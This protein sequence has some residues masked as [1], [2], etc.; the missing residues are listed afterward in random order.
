[1]MRRICEAAFLFVGTLGWWGFVYPE[2]CPVEEVYEEEAC[3]QGAYGEEVC[4]Q[5]SQEEEIHRQKAGGRRDAKAVFED[6]ESP[7]SFRESGWQ[8]GEIRIKSRLAEYV[9]QIRENA[10]EEKRLDDEG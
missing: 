8:L 1:M 5:E 4:G 7:W 3:E 2:L 6:R 9:C 10:A